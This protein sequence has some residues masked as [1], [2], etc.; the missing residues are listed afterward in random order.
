MANGRQERGGGRDEGL[1][2]DELKDAFSELLGALGSSLVSK[3]GDRLSGVTERLLDSADGLG[4]KAEKAGGLGRIAGRV[5]KGENPA[6]VMLSEKVKGMK[7]NVK[8]KLTGGGGGGGG[9]GKGGGGSGKATN[10]VEVLDVAVP[11]R[12]AYD[13]WTQFEEFSGFTKGVRGV[14]QKDEITSDWN[15]KVG[16]SSRSWKAT[17]QEQIPDDRI[18]WS[19]EGAKGTTRGAVTFHELA[20]R[21]TRI[22]LVVEY[23]PSGFFEKTGNLWRAQGRRLRLDLKHFARHVTLHGDE[24]LEGWR[25]EIR[26]G[27]VVRSHEEAMEDEE[28]AREEGREDEADDS[29]DDEPY[30][31]EGEEPYDDEEE[32]ED[33]EDD[34]EYA[35]EEDVD[36]DERAAY[37][38]EDEDDTDD[39]ERSGDSESDEDGEESEPEEGRPR[40]RRGR[41]R[42]RRGAS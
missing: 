12:T 3:A 7:D 17:V 23:F 28:N 39:D 18:V 35:D 42:G 1:P 5:V 15:L 9:G 41:G 27:E 2:I 29:L 21:L 33:A 10:I 14:S 31:D 8:D 36:D 32:D 13:Q 4:D 37:D 25:G 19:S 38:D 11:L 16:P 26:E 34:D 20:P 30:G 24:E 40:R 6:K 22:V